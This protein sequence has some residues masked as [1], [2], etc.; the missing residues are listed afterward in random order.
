[1]SKILCW[2]NWIYWN[3]TFSCNVCGRVSAIFFFF[4]GVI[5]AISHIFSLQ[6]ATF[7]AVG[8][9]IDEKLLTDEDVT[10]EI[11]RED[12]FELHPHKSIFCSSGTLI[13]NAIPCSFCHGVS[14]LYE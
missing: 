10:G 14:Y 1:L 8:D 11:H 13:E 6:D 5:H 12:K 2:C 3:C 9:E 7:D 4:F